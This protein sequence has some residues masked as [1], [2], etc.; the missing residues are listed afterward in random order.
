MPAPVHGRPAPRCFAVIREA[1]L[2]WDNSRGL[3]D[4]A[5]WT[6]HAEFMNGLVDDGFVV[7]G[8]TLGGDRRAL[9]VV[10]ADNPDAVRARLAGDPWT[11]TGML[12]LSTV[13]PWDIR[14]GQLPRR[15]PTP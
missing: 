2:G 8:G 1:G 14:L 5:G 9:L 6:E 13:D 15:Q 7:L 4:Q 3:S 11:A 12:R 10:V